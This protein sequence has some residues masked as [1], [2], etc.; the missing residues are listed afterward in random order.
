MNLRA[1]AIIQ[2]ISILAL[3]VPGLPGQAGPRADDHLIHPTTVIAK[4]QLPEFEIDVPSRTQ[5]QIAHAQETLINALG[6]G[7]QTTYQELSHLPYLI[8]STKNRSVLKRLNRIARNGQ[9]NVNAVKADTI[10]QPSLAQT[11]PLIG[12]DV[13][14]SAGAAGK[15]QVVAVIDSGA[16]L[17]HK[18]FASLESKYEACFSTTIDLGDTVSETVCPNG[19]E[20]QT[21]VSGAAAPCDV[22]KC[23]HGTH[24]SGIAVGQDSSQPLVGLAPETGLLAIQAA[25]KFTKTKHCSSPCA[26]FWFSDVLQGLNHVVDLKTAG[27]PIA[28][29]NI[30]IGTPGE[31]AD[32]I[33]R[34]TNLSECRQVDDNFLEPIFAD[35]INLGVAVVASA[36]NEG[37]SDAIGYPACLPQA[38]SVGSTDNADNLS[39]FSNRSDLLDIYAPGDSV[40]SALP[41]GQ[42]GFKPGTSMAAPHVAGA[43]AV[44]ASGELMATQD[45][46]LS[47]LQSTGVPITDPETG[48]VKPRIQVDLALGELI[49]INDGK[50]GALTAIRHYQITN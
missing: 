10:F 50:R 30:S 15:S 42:Y 24:V 4:F 43:I 1:T 9:Y 22:A 8:I 28:A 39:S 21:G 47:S 18:F 14:H 44:L 6:H 37:F 13:A 25:S 12:A 45:E 48:L 33:E 27:V 35:L 20:S 16:D 11:I 49:R 38:I 23:D 46:I 40:E 36:G 19:Q 34:I 31:E 26:R 5:A 29:V 3:L 2:A 7:E 17:S 41:G 32:N